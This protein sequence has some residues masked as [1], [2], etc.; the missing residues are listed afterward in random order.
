MQEGDTNDQ[1]DLECF[2]Q[3]THQLNMYDRQESVKAKSNCEQ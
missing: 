1:K 3:A 2:L